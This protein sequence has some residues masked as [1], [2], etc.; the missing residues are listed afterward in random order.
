VA[1][2]F[3]AFLHLR[4]P[5]AVISEKPS[6][7]SWLSRRASPILICAL[8]WSLAGAILLLHMRSSIAMGTAGLFAGSSVWIAIWMGQRSV[9]WLL[10]VIASAIWMALGAFFGLILPVSA[11]VVALLA[12]AGWLTAGWL[13]EELPSCAVS[14]KRLAISFGC[15]PVAA[16]AIL[17]IVAALLEVGTKLAPV[18]TI[19]EPEGGFGNL[20]RAAPVVV[21]AAGGAIAGALSAMLTPASLW[22]GST[23][24]PS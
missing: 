15:A 10:V 9:G 3:G 23:P 2:L 7:R 19:L 12:T 8:G 14:A 4:L 16:V 22:C 13:T 17:P 18:L 24:D 1:L 5:R 11:G 20:P 21:A 6:G